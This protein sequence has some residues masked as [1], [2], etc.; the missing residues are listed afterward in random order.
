MNVTLHPAMAKFVED[1]VQ[2]GRYAT[3]EAVIN[4][5]L[6]ILQGHEDASGMDVAALRAQIAHGIEQADR[7]ELEDWDVNEIRAEGQQL[8]AEGRKK[9]V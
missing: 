9:A 5:A 3:P 7:G 1:Q 2:S 6:S 8:L 4:G